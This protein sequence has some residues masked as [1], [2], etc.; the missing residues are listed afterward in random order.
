MRAIIRTQFGGLDVL[1]IRELR[2]VQYLHGSDPERIS[3][4]GYTLDIARMARPGVEEVQLDLILDYRSNVAL[5]PAFQQ[6]F[7]AHRPPLL[8]IWGRSGAVTRHRPLRVGN[9]LGGDRRGDAG[10]PRPGLRPVIAGELARVG[11]LALRN[12]QRR[13]GPKR[14]MKAG[15]WAV[16]QE[17]FVHCHRSEKRV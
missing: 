4:D 3:P 15:R 11:R 8:A 12:K 5:Y 10:L 2:D 7:R 9:A 6:H 17:P 14:A 1:E 13:A 16:C